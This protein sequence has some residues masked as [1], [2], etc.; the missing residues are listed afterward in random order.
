[1]IEQLTGQEMGFLWYWGKGLSW[2]QISREMMLGEQV[3]EFIA[4]D[5]Y[6]KLGFSA[7]WSW[8]IRRRKLEEASHEVRQHF[9]TRH[10]LYTLDIWSGQHELDPAMLTLVRYDRMRAEQEQERTATGILV[11]LSLLAGLGLGRLLRL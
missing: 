1:M 7:H 2:A 10:E 3:L 5:L 11:A 8:E 6:T 4:S 9:P